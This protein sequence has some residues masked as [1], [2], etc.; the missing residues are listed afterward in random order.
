MKLPLAIFLSALLSIPVFGTVPDIYKAYGGLE[1]LG[2]KLKVDSLTVAKLLDSAKISYDA[3]NFVRAVDYAE[4]SFELS[5]IFPD[6][7]FAV[8]SV[9]ILARSHKEMHLLNN[10]QQSFNSTLK[11]YLKAITALESAESKL[12]LPKIYK[13]YG[14]F[15][16]ELDLVDLTIKN[17]T[18]AYALVSAGSDY[19]FQKELLTNLAELNSA[20]S[21]YKTAVEHYS[22]L[23]EI[24][25]QSNSKSE[26]IEVLKILCDLYRVANDFDR[27]IT[28]AK[29]ALHYY[30]SINDVDNQI[31]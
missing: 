22:R 4:S 17:Y 6:S 2:G 18:K 19:G 7:D 30:Q 11:Y 3:N 8:Q 29:H 24:H 27:A 1:I 23:I 28:A 12:L 20:L 9:L 26:E 16:F 5:K 21:N 13:E 15:Y 31:T 10:D 14:D 25:K